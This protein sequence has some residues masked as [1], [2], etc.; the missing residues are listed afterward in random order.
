MGIPVAGP[1]L[2]QH[3]DGSSRPAVIARGIELSGSR[4]TH[5]VVGVLAVTEL[6][7]AAAVAVRF[8][9]DGEDLP[10]ALS[11]L[12]GVFVFAAMAYLSSRR[13]WQAHRRFDSGWSLS[14]RLFAVGIGLLLIG[15]LA[16]VLVPQS[17]FYESMVPALGL[18]TCVLGFF[19]AVL[20]L[21]G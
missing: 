21:R 8:A 19:V 17:G 7:V 1:E 4:S 14:P 5:T 20:G 10:A 3:P 6:F 16:V 2:G 18:V 12:F 13:D 11:V 9:R 15:A